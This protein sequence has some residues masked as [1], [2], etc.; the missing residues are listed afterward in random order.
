MKRKLSK[1]TDEDLLRLLR[2]NKKDSEEAFTEIYDRYALKVNAYCRTIIGNKEQAEDLF[3]ETFIRF[4]QNVHVEHPNTTIIGYLIKI[5]RNLCLNFKRDQK[6]TVSIENLDFSVQADISF[7]DKELNDLILVAI[8]LLDSETK[9]VITM[10]VFNDMSYNEI[11]D[12][13]G[14]TSAR[15][16]YLV[17]NGKQKIKQIL[18]PY[19]KDIYKY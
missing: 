11:A 16:R 5:A 4:Y 14:I 9:E 3:Q 2:G 8:D 7:E 12:T 13:L 1:Y 18:D 10:R 15:A 19:I 6:H 17:F